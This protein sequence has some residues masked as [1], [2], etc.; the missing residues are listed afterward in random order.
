MG[1]WWYD[2]YDDEYEDDDYTLSDYETPPEAI[3]LGGPVKATSTRGAIGKEWWGQQWV[4]AMERLG[5]GGR[6]DR[7]RRY[8]RNGSV[9]RMEISHGMAYADV[10]GSRPS[11]YR[12]AVSLK[13]FN[14]K[15]WQKALAALSGQAIYAAKLLAGE[16]PAD[17]EAF[18]QS[19]G[20]SLF[21]RS[22][23]DIV[24]TCSCPDWGDPCKHAA[25]VYYLLAE[26]LDADPFIL[27]HLRGLTREQVLAVLRSHRRA[28]I[29]EG[30]TVL[31]APDTP[32]LDADLRG[33]WVGSAVNLIRSAPVRPDQPPLL[34][35]LGE[36]PGGMAGALR[37][38][39]A[40]IS[41]EAYR[42]LGLDEEVS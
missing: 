7:G 31:A 21:P 33:F 42:W 2:N 3:I 11:P 13:T 34:R 38:L 30:D 14:D 40:V 37:D 18:F 4:T 36:P 1:G 12:T 32:P 26:Q 27:L 41:D 24:F 39:Y 35:Q 17:I 15:E 6:L 16:M 19:V 23:K 20:L 5:V 28:A 10:Q 25:A 29:N 9:R 22:L 8:A